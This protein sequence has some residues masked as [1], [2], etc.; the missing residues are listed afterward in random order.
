MPLSSRERPFQAS[1]PNI[2]TNIKLL[3][4]QHSS[5]LFIEKKRFLLRN[6]MRKRGLCC[7]PVSVCLSV[8]P[9]VT[10]VYCIQKAEDI[11]KLHSRL[12]S[13]IIPLF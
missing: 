5:T 3:N 13:P 1:G 12:G 8:R 11:L 7:R 2:E 4:I 9:S 10:F 6:A